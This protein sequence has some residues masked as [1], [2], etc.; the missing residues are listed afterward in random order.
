[1]EVTRILVD[2]LAEQLQSIAIPLWDIGWYQSR[3]NRFQ[4]LRH[5]I[6]QEFGDCEMGQS[7][8][9]AFKATLG[10]IPTVP[11]KQALFGPINV[12][13]VFV[14]EHTKMFKGVLKNVECVNLRTGVKIV[15]VC[16]DIRLIEL[17]ALLPPPENPR[18]LDEFSIFN[19]LAHAD[20]INLDSLETISAFLKPELEVI[21]MAQIFGRILYKCQR[22]RRL[23]WRA[24]SPDL[25][26]ESMLDHDKWAMPVD[27]N[28]SASG[29]AIGSLSFPDSTKQPRTSGRYTPRIVAPLETIEYFSPILTHSHIIDN[30]LS[31]F[32]SSLRRLRV[33]FDVTLAT[34]VNPQGMLRSYVIIGGDTL[35]SFRRL[36]YLSVETSVG[37][38]VW[39]RPA[40]LG[41]SPLVK[42]EIDNHVSWTAESIAYTSASWVAPLQASQLTVL[43]LQGPSSVTFHPAT[44]L[45]SKDLE[46]VILSVGSWTHSYITSNKPLPGL[47]LEQQQVLK[48]ASWD[49]HLPR[50]TSLSLSDAFATFFQFRMLETCPALQYLYLNLPSK[51]HLTSHELQKPRT[52]L[53][54]DGNQD[55]I[56]QAS[57]KQTSLFSSSKDYISAPALRFL[58]M[59]GPWTIPIESWKVLVKSVVPNI[60]DLRVPQSSGFDLRVWVEEIQSMPRLEDVWTSFKDFKDD[61]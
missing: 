41:E 25:L 1:M 11:P 19:F 50:L 17:A 34:Y 32:C 23:S 57:G 40:A 38:C 14:K 4:S 10:L 6:F 58:S 8:K 30:I 5:V 51:R 59:D 26:C 24:I 42:L 56:T 21:H 29:D 18:H 39:L 3:I 45:T 47:L 9:D 52:D 20:E 60:K 22:L 12:M 49:W 33:V 16:P 35:P 27:D 36:Q 31:Y 43:H 55:A 37:M 13:T 15:R 7:S 48:S 2:G 28:G 53:S 61:E 54:R 46:S 44:F